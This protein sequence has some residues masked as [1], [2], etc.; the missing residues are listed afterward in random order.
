ML[1]EKNLNNEEGVGIMLQG[2]AGTGKSFV[3]NLIRKKFGDKVIT[4]ATTGSAAFSIMGQTIHSCLGLQRQGS[5]NEY[6][7]SDEKIE[8]FKNKKILIID[9]VS[10]LSA[11]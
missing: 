6:K 7:P 2:S 9:E 1:I 11:A 3:I 8:F 4:T 5:K 10:M